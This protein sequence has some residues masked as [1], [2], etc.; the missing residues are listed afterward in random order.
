M[1]TFTETKIVLM[2][3]EAPTEHWY[4]DDHMFVDLDSS[5]GGYPTRAN[6]RNAYDFKTKEKADN[7]NCGVNNHFVVAELTSVHTVKEL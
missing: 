4:S 7:Y 3:K 1:T 2:Y 6:A 5:S